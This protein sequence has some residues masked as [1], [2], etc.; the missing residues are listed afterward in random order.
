MLGFGPEKLD[1]DSSYQPPQK[2]FPDG[3]IL[4]LTVAGEEIEV[5]PC[6]SDTTC[7]VAFWFPTE[8]AR[9]QLHGDTL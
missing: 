1:R 9:H 8:A 3:Q 2:T 4:Q 7:S 6:R 5:A